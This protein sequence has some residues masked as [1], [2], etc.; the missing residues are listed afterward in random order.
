[1]STP[2]RWPSQ[3]KPLDK[4]HSATFDAQPRYVLVR[5]KVDPKTGKQKTSSSS[6]GLI[7]IA[8]AVKLGLLPSKGL[9]GV[10]LYV[11]HQKVLR[12][13]KHNTVAFVRPKKATT[14]GNHVTSMMLKLAEEALSVVLGPTYWQANKH[15]GPKAALKTTSA[16]LWI[17]A[18]LENPN[19]PL[20]N[21]LRGTSYEDIIG[22]KHSRRWW[23]DSL[24]IRKSAE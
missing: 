4:N 1:M 24:K 18:N 8:A 7:D 2:F 22:L 3:L 19:S 20:C 23:L 21:S 9:P 11:K 5:K 10:L 15:L 16:I 6:D 12:L 14:R 13:L 17:K